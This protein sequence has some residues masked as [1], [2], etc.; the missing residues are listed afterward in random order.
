MAKNKINRIKNNRIE[1]EEQIEIKRFIII[2]LI[3]VIL[4]IGIYFFTRIF[5]TKDLFGDKD[6]NSN[7]P[8]TGK[9]DYNTTLIG[10]M[11][12]KPEEEYF[13]LA[14]KSDDITSDV[15]YSGL[16]TNY[17]KS[18]KAL[19]V[20]IADLSNELNKKYYDKENVNTSSLETLKLGD[21]TLLKITKGT[22]AAVYTKEEDITKQLKYVSDA[23]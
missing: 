3:L 18:T 2:L 11:L 4:V 16:V 1:S 17:K 15:Y 20:Y 13:V 14:Y 9:V 6:E 23:K 10:A 7:T 12:N 22:I 21:V 5:V 8:I 19:K